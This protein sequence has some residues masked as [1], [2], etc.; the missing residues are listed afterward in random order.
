VHRLDWVCRPTNARQVHR[1]I[2][3][4]TLRWVDH[5]GHNPYEPAM[6]AVLDQAIRRIRETAAR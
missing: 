2:A 6:L 1:A 5:G 4:S 3:G